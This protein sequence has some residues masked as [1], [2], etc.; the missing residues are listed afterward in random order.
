MFLNR[1]K[2]YLYRGT[3]YIVKGIPN[4]IVNAQIVCS[5][6]SQKLANKTIII[7]GGNRGLGFAMAKKF[8]VEGATIL[9]CGRDEISL[10]NKAKEL[11]C[12]YLTLDIQDT[13]SFPS[14]L[15]Q[16]EN[17]IGIINCLVNN[18]GISSHEGDYMNVTSETFEKQ[19]NTNL[20]GSYFLTQEFIKYIKL[21]NID[22]SQ[23]LF[24]SSER[25]TYSDYMPY[26]LTKASINSLVKCLAYMYAKSGI[27]VNAIAPGI[28]CSDMIGVKS[29]DNLYSAYNLK[30]R[31]YLPEE[32]AEVATFL[33]SDISSCVSGQIIECNNGRS[34][35]PHWK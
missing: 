27:R 31:I 20:K 17:K 16:A 28:T 23:I 6:P 10:I 26:G 11:D 9:I 3:E 13:D 25:G 35:N 21:H 15:K 19:F 33:L 34:A 4:N 2:K 8:K 29:T 5:S 7:T 32:V 1:I 12:Q 24:T 30:N 22:N 18:A 14:F